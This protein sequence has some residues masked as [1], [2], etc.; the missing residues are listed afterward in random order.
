MVRFQFRFR[1]PGELPAPGSC[2]VRPAQTSATLQLNWTTGE[3]LKCNTTY[4]VDVRVSKDAGATWCIDG[5]SPAC[6]GSG[7]TAWGK[8]CNVNI[9]SSTYCPNPFQGGGSS[10][11]LQEEHELT[12]YPNPNR[13]DQ[14]FIGLSA[15]EQGV[16]AIQVD[17]FDLSGKRISTHNIA[18]DEGPFN[19]AMELPGGL[20]GGLYLLQLTAGSKMY[21]ERS[22]IQP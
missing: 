1:I 3:K 13:G 18:V 15:I 6:S 10:L 8:I 19:T 22:V 7:Y 4:E 12:L 5:A 9:T 14:L 11:A 2:I 20:T 21:S 16:N 17:L